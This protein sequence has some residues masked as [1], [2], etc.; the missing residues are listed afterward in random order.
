MQEQASALYVMTTKGGKHG[1][2]RFFSNYSFRLL[3]M[4]LRVLRTA[5]TKTREV[6]YYTIVRPIHEGGCQ[7]WNPHLKMDI[8]DLEKV[9]NKALRFIFLFERTC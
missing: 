3:G 8:T 4:L 2:L 6:T 1:R 9:Q 5:D 7:V